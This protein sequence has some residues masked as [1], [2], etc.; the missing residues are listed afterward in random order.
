MDPVLD[1]EARRWAGAYGGTTAVVPPATQ[2]VTNNN[3]ITTNISGVL[4]DR[5]TVDQIERIIAKASRE[6]QE[7]GP[8][9][10]NS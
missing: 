5:G 3:E 9:V 10:K 1:A 6:Q 7:R 2:P 4:T 8:V